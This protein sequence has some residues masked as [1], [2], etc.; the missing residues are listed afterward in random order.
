[1]T[2]ELTPEQRDIIR[3]AVQ[4]RLNGCNSAALALWD[5]PAATK[6]AL[7]NEALRLESLLSLLNV[8]HTTVILHQP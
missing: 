6:T 7:T 5:A 8:P 3:A 1:M 2:L 4:T